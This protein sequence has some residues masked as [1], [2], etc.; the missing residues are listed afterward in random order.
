MPPG[1]RLDT[2]ATK[3]AAGTV[4]RWQPAC[5]AVAAIPSGDHRAAA[6][7]FET[8]FQP[9]RARLPAGK[10]GQFTG[11]YEAEI[12]ASRVR[13][14]RYRFPVYAVPPSLETVTAPDGTRKRMRRVGGSLKPF[15]TRR[16]IE[17]GDVAAGWPVLL[18]TDDPVDLFVLH[19]Q[20]AARVRL[21]DGGATRVGYA[22]DN[23]HG[24]VAIGRLMIDR[25]LLGPGQAD[26]RSIRAWLKAN[27]EQARAL[28]AE[29][30][31][32]IFFRE[33]PAGKDGPIGA[34]GVPL[35]AGRSL[36]VDPS[37]VPYHT[38]LW[39]STAWP[40]GGRKLNR[41]V[42]AQDTGGAIRGPVRGDL[43]WGTGEA[44]L[45]F[46]GRMNQRGTFF[47]LLPRR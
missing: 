42:V 20:G 11:Y 16:E 26:M 13:T 14:P 28:M 22:A 19:I 3:D 44:A 32:Y 33:M 9:Y 41:L 45:R 4:R 29:N 25:G 12:R 37:F 31:R 2:S 15:H 1:R 46:A 18:W 24:F 30:P 17:A 35:T 40:G 39:L 27:P 5:R 21:A 8:W 43:Y 36:A 7:Y 10:A 23:G 47:L 6:R 34:A 38:P